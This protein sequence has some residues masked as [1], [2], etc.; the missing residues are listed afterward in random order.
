MLKRVY[1]VFTQQ[2]L[3]KIPS[4]KI[5]K[6]SLR[7]LPIY[8]VLII[9]DFR[10]LSENVYQ[11]KKLAEF[12]HTKTAPMLFPGHLQTLLI[13]PWP[14]RIIFFISIYLLNIAFQ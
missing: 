4:A 5:K 7:F 3:K 12:S 2:K 9:N 8:I 11:E 6:K 1:S 10:C 14:R 13:F